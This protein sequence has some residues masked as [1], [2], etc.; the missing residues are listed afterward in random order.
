VTDLLHSNYRVITYDRRG[1]GL[2]SRPS[3]GYDFDTFSEDLY[4]LILE[5][6]LSEATLI[7]HSM[8]TGEIS[9][10]LSTYGA[11]RISRAVFISPIL[12][13]LLKTEDNPSGA[14]ASTFE[15]TKLAITS[16]RP[17]Y[18][19]EFLKKFYKTQKHLGKS[20]ST[21]KISFDF[22]LGTSASAIATYG[23]VDS[24]QTDFRPDLSKITIPCLII[25][26]EAD[27]ILPIDSTAVPLSEAL[28]ARLVKIADGSHGIPWTHAEIV[29]KEILDFLNDYLFNR[30]EIITENSLQ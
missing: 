19:S 9:R 22:N 17:A 15:E 14:E 23:C 12:P 18:I 6:D 20:V 1:F 26:G 2:S 4:K 27:A 30:V 5:L 29:N 3:K 7:G 11:D 21:E 24:W 8:G 28:A 16:D 13:F 25:H 10:Y